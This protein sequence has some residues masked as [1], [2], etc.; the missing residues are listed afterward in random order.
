VK[1]T[2]A[3]R[4]GARSLPY[5]E[6]WALVTNDARLTGIE[7]AR[8][9]WQEQ[10]FRDLK[11]GGWRW[12]ESRVRRPE[13][14]SNLLI[15]LVLAYV[16]LVALGSQAVTAGCARHLL[17][18]ADGSQ[19]RLWSLFKEGLRYWFEVVQR[20][21]VCRG[22]VFIPDTRFTSNMS[23]PQ[24]VVGEGFGEGP[25]GTSSRLLEVFN[26]GRPEIYTIEISGACKSLRQM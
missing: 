14:V 16:W 3:M 11:S 13:H 17:R 8:R 21:S 7:Y 15:L 2:V 6:P 9:N 24:R 10:S 20:Q 23:S 25:A 1:P 19:R 5:N 18:R 12:G 22:L 26:F 4:Q